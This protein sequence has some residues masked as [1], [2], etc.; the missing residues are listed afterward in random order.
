MAKKVKDILK[1]LFPEYQ[2]KACVDE[3]GFI[4]KSQQERDFAQRTSQVYTQGEVRQ[5][6]TQASSQPIQRIASAPN[7]SQTAKA[8]QKTYTP[9]KEDTKIVSKANDAFAGLADVLKRYWVGTEKERDAICK[10]YQRPYVRGFDDKKPKNAILLI[11]S[12]SRGRVY[13]IRCISELL[14][15]KKVFRYAEVAIIDFKDYT[16]DSSNTLFLSDLYKAL[17]TNTETVVFENIDKALLTQLDV[18]YQLLTDGIYKL[19][20]R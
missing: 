10:A 6:A 17:N 12:E 11:G 19:S 3:R 7:V 1:L 18:I 9:M 2:I 16:S 5:Q 15:Q 8:G 20:K 4:A 13:A 14:R